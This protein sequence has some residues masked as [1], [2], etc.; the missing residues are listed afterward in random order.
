MAEV[1][2]GKARTIAGGIFHASSILG[3][4][5]AALQGMFISGEHWRTGFAL[6]LLPAL[7]VVWVLASLKESKKWLESK[8]ES[9]RVPPN[10]RTRW[11]SYV[12]TGDGEAAP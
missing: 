3:V 1:F 10:E 2:T 11:W 4:V 5:L 7:L 8:E 12:A 9:P 6:G